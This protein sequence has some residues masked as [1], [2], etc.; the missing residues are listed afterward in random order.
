MTTIKLIWAGALLSLAAAAQQVPL[1]PPGEPH[2]ETFE[3][4]IIGHGAGGVLM[5]ADGPAQGMRQMTMQYVSSEAGMPGKLVKGMPYSAE[6]ITETTQVLA[7]GNR[8]RHKSSSQV[9]R[10]SEGRTRRETKLQG[11]GMAPSAELPQL[12]F[13]NDPV[14]GYNY[15]VNVQEKSAQKSKMMA[16]DERMAELKRKFEQMAK[17]R[18]GKADAAEVGVSKQIVEKM[19]MQA[20]TPGTRVQTYTYSTDGGDSHGIHPNI[21]T[22]QLPAQVIEGVTVE[23]TRSTHTIA[24]GEM[25]NERPIEIVNETWFSPE[26]QTVV[27]SKHSD[28]RMGETVFKLSNVSRSEPA[29]SL[30]QVPADFQVNEGSGDVLFRA[31]K[32]PQK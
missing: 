5:Q 27:M 14:T 19:A 21:K 18:G 17:E 15:V 13:I 3:H 2:M 28:P 31:V 12:V 26:L 29:P 9:Y 25:G 8:I 24:A 30:F 22:E 7:D 32:K 11:I 10:D 6:A 16:P 4:H 20:G 1:P 23:G